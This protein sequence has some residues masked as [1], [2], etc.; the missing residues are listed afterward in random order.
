VSTG[1]I[2]GPLEDETRRH[3]VA[4]WVKVALLKVQVRVGQEVSR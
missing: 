1:W 4:M 3:P 2:D